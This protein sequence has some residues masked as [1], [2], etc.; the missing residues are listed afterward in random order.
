MTSTERPSLSRGLGPS[1]PAN[2]APLVGGRRKEAVEQIARRR[3][4]RSPLIRIGAGKWIDRRRFRLG[5]HEGG[6][7]LR[8]SV[9]ARLCG[10]FCGNLHL[11]DDLVQDTLLKALGSMDSFTKGTDLKAWLFTILRNT[12]YTKSG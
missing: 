2:G 8:H 3:N 1:K 12:Y 4:I 7:R 9:A 6:H 11:A 10:V 5:R